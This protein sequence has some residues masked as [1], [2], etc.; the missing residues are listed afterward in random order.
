MRTND[1]NLEARYRKK[2]SKEGIDLLK[3]LIALNENERPSAAQALRHPFF[4]D[5]ASQDEELITLFKTTE[6]ENNVN[7]PNTKT[8]KIEELKIGQKKSEFR[9]TSLDKIVSS[10]VKEN[11]SFAIDQDS[12]FRNKRHL[13]NTYLQ[14]SRNYC[15]YGQNSEVILSP[16][17]KPKEYSMNSAAF[18]KNNSSGQHP[19]K[20]KSENMNYKIKNSSKKFNTAHSINFVL[21]NMQTLGM[22]KERGRLWKKEPKYDVQSNFALPLINNVYLRK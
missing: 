15:F 13:D 20:N 17:L 21:K 9:I 18:N 14:P 8:P 1:D 6:K 7:N 12:G 5:L 10:H 16:S 3:K 22:K 19:L 4:A 11:C 2:A